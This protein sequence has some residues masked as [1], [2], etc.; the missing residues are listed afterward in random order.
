MRWKLRASIQAQPKIYRP[1]G[2]PSRADMR[3]EAE[4]AVAEFEARRGADHVA[5]MLHG[6][7][8]SR[9]EPL[10]I[11]GTA[12]QHAR[13]EKGRIE[14]RPISRLSNEIKLVGEVGLEPTKA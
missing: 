7:A 11:C 13:H 2:Q 10:E 8:V 1:P 4:K 14:G 5:F 3:A 9:S 6:A 12:S